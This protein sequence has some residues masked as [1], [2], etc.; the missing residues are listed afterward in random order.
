MA[1]TDS[2][3]LVVVRLSSD[4]LSEFIK[5]CGGTTFVNADQTQLQVAWQLGVQHAVNILR[6]G[7]TIA[8]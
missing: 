8:D 3:Q 1:D 7:F 2:K 5:Q 4:Q 6:K